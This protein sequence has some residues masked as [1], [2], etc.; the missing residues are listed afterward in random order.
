MKERFYEKRLEKHLVL[1]GYCPVST[2]CLLLSDGESGAV[3]VERS[4]RLEPP[5]SLPF[6]AAELNAV[7]SCPHFDTRKEGFM[8]KDWKSPWYWICLALMVI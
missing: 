8:R 3:A 7:Q 1:G 6:T 5:C 4:A 2:M